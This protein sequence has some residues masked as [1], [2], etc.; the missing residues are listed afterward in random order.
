MTCLKIEP[1]K[2]KLT[3]DGNGGTTANGATKIELG[4]EA[5]QSITLDSLG[6]T[7]QGYY[8]NGFN[9]AVNAY[10]VSINGDSTITLNWVETGYNQFLALDLNGEKLQDTTQ[11]HVY[12]DNNTGKHVLFVD[13]TN[14]TLKIPE[15]KLSNPNS[16]ILY[17]YTSY[18]TK[19]ERSDSKQFFTG[20]TITKED[21][22]EGSTLYAKG[23]GSNRNIYLA[24]SAN[25]KTFA[26]GRRIITRSSSYLPRLTASDGAK[27]HYYSTDPEGK[28]DRYMPEEYGN[29]SRGTKL[30]AIWL[31]VGK[32]PV[33]IENR[34]NNET[35]ETFAEPGGTMTLEKLTADGLT[36]AYWSYT[37]KDTSGNYSWGS[38]EAGESLT[39]PDDAA[40]VYLAA[41]W[42]PNAPVKVGNNEY[43]FAVD[44]LYHSGDGWSIWY[45]LQNVE[46]SLTLDGYTGGGIELPVQTDVS[47]EGYT[48]STITGTLTCADTLSFKTDC[49]YGEH[50]ELTIEPASGP[51]I[52]A[53]RVYFERAPH[54]TLKAQ[55][56]STA[57]ADAPEV[58]GGDMV[59]YHTADAMELTK[60]DLGVLSVA[61]LREFYTRAR[62]S[63]LTLDGN[64]GKTADGADS[65][66]VELEY[67]EGYNLRGTGFKKQY[68]DVTGVTEYTGDNTYYFYDWPS[69]IYVQSHAVTLTMNWRTRDFPYI[70]FRGNGVMTEPDVTG[71]E[72]IQI[73]VSYFNK[74][75]GEVRVPNFVY[76]DPVSNGDLVYWFTSED[77]RTETENSHQYLAGELV[78]EPDD[79]TL[80]ARAIRWG[81]VALVA[82]GTTFAENGAHVM[83][84]DTLNLKD[85]K[86]KEGWVL[87][88]WNSAPDGSGTK[89]ELD[90][91]LLTE[92][93]TKHR[94]LYAQWTTKLAVEKTET[95][96]GTVVTFSPKTSG[97]VTIP[98]TNEGDDGVTLEKATRV[99]LAAY[100]NG[101]FVGMLSATAEGSKIT[102]T[103]PKDSK[104]DGCELKLFF[105]DGGKPTQEMEIVRLYG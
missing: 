100:K 59:T 57:F 29:L 14:D 16:E 34:A 32:I 40:S 1:K 28:A 25:G 96:T 42:L 95:E 20:E 83:V 71:D 4:V 63:T 98:V 64:G 33:T 74:N 21:V 18:G 48:E 50:S 47:V 45:N 62:M 75:I 90:T 43:T 12:I 55:E 51:A 35:T 30:Y 77:G 67:G 7:K 24:I 93:D 37:I 86:A 13:Y 82:T 52:D 91:N 68:S 23:T 65:I 6:F 19:Y 69:S 10:D 87:E 8:R 9:N 89:Y 31:P 105:I 44:H 84:S 38:V 27:V 101:Q 60:D 88:S 92:V 81:Q 78:S 79:T 54:V 2:V 97:G 46:L 85:L 17:W 61:G 99:V 104:Y 26:G 5:E 3:V 80:Y 41:S 66:K 53:P 102:C 70:A 58:T 72:N 39:I 103:I 22:P 76:D 73:R 94:I 49:A 11:E 36:F 56:G 15:V